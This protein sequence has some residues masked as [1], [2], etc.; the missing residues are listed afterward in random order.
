MLEKIYHQGNYLKNICVGRPDAS[1]KCD[2]TIPDEVVRPETTD[3]Q[4]FMER[5][6][7]FQTI[8]NLLDIKIRPDVDPDVIEDRFL[9]PLLF[10]TCVPTCTI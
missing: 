7:A 9:H 3:A 6:W 1:L 10:V 8:K 4:K 5:M 2:L